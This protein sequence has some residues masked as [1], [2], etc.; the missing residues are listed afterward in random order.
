MSTSARMVK[1]NAASPRLIGRIAGVC[2]LSEALTATFGQVIIL[3]RLIVIGNA[4]ATAT[5]FLGHQRLVWIG[6]ASS[7]LAAIFHIAWSY[8][9]YDLLKPVN[10]RIA[11][12]GLLVMVMGCVMQAVTA[13]LYIAPLLVL[14]GGS[15]LSALTTGQLQSLAAIFLKLNGYAFDIQTVYFGLWCVLTGYLIYKS[16]FL[17]K[18]LGIL[19]AIA[20]MGWSLYLFPPFAVSIFPVI[21]ALSAMGEIPLELWLIVK[22][23]N[24]QR[25]NEQAAAAGMSRLV[26]NG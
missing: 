22:S 9:M 5:N 21:A 15:S 10:R 6:F 18:I 23:V 17:P 4:A 20:G 14:Q 7:V 12:F 11:Q 8:L 3:G 26:E 24:E 25:W 13:V 19:F 2:Q 16:T 1:I